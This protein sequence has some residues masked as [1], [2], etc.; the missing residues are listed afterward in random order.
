MKRL[1]TSPSLNM[2]HYISRIVSGAKDD[3]EVARQELFEWIANQPK[4]VS[5]LQRYNSTP[6]GL[7]GL[8]S[9]LIQAGAGQ[10]SGGYFVAAA[11]FTREET[12]RHILAVAIAPL[13]KG[14]SDW[15]RW[16]QLSFD[17]VEHFRIGK[18]LQADY[19]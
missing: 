6:E 12:L 8:Y 17:L 19:Q 16:L 15:D 11:A 4:L 13:P 3:K 7:C 9:I 5:I 14:W 1:G 2:D 18:S 10:W